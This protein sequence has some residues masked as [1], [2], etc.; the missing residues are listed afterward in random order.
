MTDMALQEKAYTIGD[1][2][3]LTEH[4]RVVPLTAM[5][6]FTTRVAIETF[7][8]F[9]ADFSGAGWSQL[10]TA[11]MMRNRLMHPKRTE[12]LVIDI[13]DVETAKAGLFWFCD[14]ATRGMAAA[15]IRFVQYNAEARELT[16]KLIS[17]D[18]ETLAAYQEAVNSV[19][20]GELSAP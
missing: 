10:K 12:D 16:E 13:S 9:V 11:L 5:I 6:R 18:V 17:G 3:R 19:D 15:N 14:L 2:G 7:G 1:D 4:I 20:S 8:D